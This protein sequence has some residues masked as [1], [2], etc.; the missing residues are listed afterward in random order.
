MISRRAWTPIILGVTAASLAAG[1]DT[2]SKP[3]SQSGAS[4]S[5]PSVQQLKASRS[6]PALFPTPRGISYGTVTT[7]GAATVVHAFSTSSRQ[8][9]FDLYQRDLASN[10]YQVSKRQFGGRD[11]EIYFQGNGVNGRVAVLA[12]C[13][14]VVPVDITLQQAAL[15]GR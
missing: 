12:G 8:I 14:G 10:P 6:L 11:A 15:T 3:A 2:G 7:T 1:C 5:H 4:C 9:T 13:Q